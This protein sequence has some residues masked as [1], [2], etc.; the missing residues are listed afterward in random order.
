MDD[1]SRR[2][3]RESRRFTTC[4]AG[5]TSWTVC[6]EA[7]AKASSTPART[8]F[9]AALEVAARTFEIAAARAFEISSCARSVAAGLAGPLRILAL[10]GQSSR[11]LGEASIGWAIL[12][13]GTA[14]GEWLGLEVISF[15]A[16]KIAVL[17]GLHELGPR[18][19]AES[20]AA[21]RAAT[22]FLRSIEAAFRLCV[23]AFALG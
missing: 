21:G 2:Y 13:K 3:R 9:A 18:E 7:L 1:A 5:G 22:L 20:E 6:T 19:L 10:S 4:A 23:S 17:A 11:L 8:S 16:A 14:G 15:I 12:G